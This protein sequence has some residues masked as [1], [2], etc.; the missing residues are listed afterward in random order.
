MCYAML[1]LLAF[2]YASSHGTY[3]NV[4]MDV[5][6][7]Q[8]Q[9]RILDVGALGHLSTEAIFKGSSI[10]KWYL[11]APLLAKGLK[12]GNTTCQGQ[13]TVPNASVGNEVFQFRPDFMELLACQ[14][15][16]DTAW[17]VQG[18]RSI[19]QKFAAL[20]LLEHCCTREYIYFFFYNSRKQALNLDK[21]T[22]EQLRRPIQLKLSPAIARDFSVRSTKNWSTQ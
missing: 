13:T 22:R 5:V 19:I 17:A 3:S 1:T 2:L 11:R 7:S 8:Y 12:E 16:S 18:M 20:I 10:P 9:F 4:L 21:K 15:S 14:T 6:D